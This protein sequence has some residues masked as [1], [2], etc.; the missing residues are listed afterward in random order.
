MKMVRLS[1][2]PLAMLLC[3]F[4]VVYASGAY[5]DVPDQMKALIEQKRALEAYEIGNEHPELM[6]EP[7]FDYFYGVAAV[8]SGRTSLGVLALERVLLNDPNNDLVRLEL[9][10]AYFTLGEYQRA[11]EEF[12]TVKKHQ[13]PAGVITTI[14]VYLDQID[15]KEGRQKINYSLYVELGM[16]T[17]S[18]VNSATAVST[19]TLPFVGPVV[20]G[21]TS[22]PQKSVFSYDSVG[23]NV[24]IPLD[25][26]LVGFVNINTSA[27]RYSQVNGYNLNVSNGVTG[28]KYADGPNLY[29]LAAFGNVAQ[30]DQVPV[31]N[32]T[33]GGGEYV[34]QLNNTQSIMLGAGSTQMLYSAGNTAYNSTLNAST[35]GFRQALPTFKWQPVI[36][37]NA[38]LANQINLSSRPDLGRHIGGGA[39]QLSFLPTEKIGVTVGA[40]Y[41]RSNYGASDLI[42]QQSRADNLLSGNLV[43]QY[44]LTK[45]LSARLEGTYYNNNSNLSLYTYQ[46]WT[47]A[48]KLRYDWSS[49]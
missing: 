15:V 13:P 12:D 14:N 33:G 30:V 7:L 22:Q 36:D 28:L 21:S 3:L 48:I 45:D 38:N 2:A 8:D 19:I 37:L 29:K 23:G 25:T 32:T 43:F 5:A 18:N 49:I 9:A 40:G 17:N 41:A 6:G 16:G 35:L 42:Y 4:T 39:V 10:R 11:K 26:N 31:P 27:Q 20:L 47:G 46:Q 24:N 1:V 44:R 34:R